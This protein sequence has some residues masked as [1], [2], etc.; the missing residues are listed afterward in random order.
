MD[1]LRARLE[2]ALA[3]RYTIERELGGGG[4]SRTYLAREVALNRRVVVKVLAPELL[5][6]IS[7]ERFRREVLLAA[8][9]QHPHVVPVLAAGDTDGI[10]WFTMPYVAGDSL[11]HRLEGG[12]LP[13]A[14]AVSIL[15]DV[16]R[17]LAYAHGQGVVHRDIKPDNVLL[18]SGSA[19]VTDFG[20]AKAI[21]AART[22]GGHAGG[23]THDTALTQAGMS[24]GTPMYMAPEQA[25]GDPAID[26]RADLY[27]FGV[28]AYEIIAGHPPFQGSTPSKLLAAHMGEPPRDLLELAPDCPK[29]LSAIV[30]S[31]LAKD[32]EH[33]PQEARDVAKV[34]DSI[35][36][37]GS[38]A[39][40]PAI[41]QGGQ[42]HLARATGVWA[43][44]TAF[45]TLTAWAATSVVDLP[46]WVLPGSVVV[47]LAGLPLIAFTAF[48]QRTARR[49]FTAT[50][51]R[52]APQGTMT[53]MAISAS[54]H[55]S[56]RRVWL[57]GGVAVGAF[58]ALV[59]GFMVMRAMGIGPMAS[60]RSS[61]TFGSQETVM[62][63]D[64]TSPASDSTLG[65]T[66]AEA[67][68]TD[69]AQSSSLKVLTRAAIRDLLSWMKRPTDVPLNFDV[70][71]EIATLEGAKAVLD[72]S[73]QQLGSSYV[74][75]ARLVG[76]LDG[77]E[78]ALFRQE[79]ANQDALLV[80]VGKL[81]RQVRSKAGE[82][83]RTIRASRELERV[84]TSSLPALRKYVEGSR[85]ADEQAEPERGVALLREAVEIDSSFAMA[86]RK[87]AVLLGN[88]DLDRTGR[89]EAI[90][91][92]WRHRERLT[93]MERLL[94]EGY[95]HLNGPT[96]DL[97][98]AAAAYG[99]AAALDSTSA[100][101][102]N[103]AAVVLVMKRDYKGAESL[104]RKVTK[105][106]R[107]FGGA[108]TNLLLMQIGTG[109]TESLDSTVQA[110][111]VA[112]PQSNNIWEAEAWA[113][114]GKGDYARMDS[115]SRSIATRP[116]TLRQATV[117]ASTVAQVAELQGRI[118]EARQWQ[119]KSGE[120]LLQ[121]QPT[122]ANRLAVALDTVYF[123]AAYGDKPS[124][125][126][127]LQRGLKRAPMA[128]IPATERPWELL[129]TIAL[130]LRDPKLMRT[131]VTG[132]EQ[133]LVSSASDLA[134]VRSVLSAGLAY[135]EGRWNDAIHEI[136]I[137]DRRFETSE[138]FADVIRGL[139]W[140]ELG[141]ADSAISAFEHFLATPSVD[142]D[143]DARWRVTV[144]RSLGEL[145]EANG[146]RQKAIDVYSQITQL[147]MKADPALQPWVQEIRARVDKLLRQSG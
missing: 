136:T 55:L 27:A 138:R 143:I 124:A 26:H 73:I 58:A 21:N 69:L 117:S 42:I 142:L 92:A 8:Q 29:A 82:S 97:D 121:A 119:A 43:A 12:P 33:R 5:A 76:A 70:A 10:P 80:A 66:V 144:L 102:L 108:F 83:L 31:C 134:G 3:A 46:D 125:L 60:L 120:A 16:A 41:L 51:G 62:V 61:G 20:I 13:Q 14:E 47:M 140:K 71:R 145:Y 4:M 81:S 38:G 88:E 127:A 104:F 17:A 49:V 106:P 1:A 93:E 100:S 122:V 86:W 109:Q 90:S 112:F 15:R 132:A 98:K 59:V 74:V 147:W 30:M 107:T 111:R 40:T 101:A 48:T 78:L 23:D 126:E 11:R 113:A 39:V 19:T 115:L 96:R 129:G 64:F 118:R 54:P 63:A 67:L 85:L 133:D 22:D 72:G 91:T 139:S 146:Q 44:A 87:L 79:A 37:T 53:T 123:E 135:T 6:N 28:M 128:D 56:W 45:V 18:S 89:I 25:F 84:T 137:A 65:A 99:A 130:A 2:T 36:T 24:I 103:A 35:T 9:L 50:P 116:K 110:F 114:F 95:Y 34:L 52:A 77:R 131:A 7:V 57:G 141:R 94:T 75:S 105:L 68:R 32:P